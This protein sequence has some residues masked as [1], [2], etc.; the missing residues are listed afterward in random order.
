MDNLRRYFNDVGE[1]PLLSKEEEVSLSKKIKKGCKESFNTFIEHNLRLVYSIAVNYQGCGV[2]LMDLISEGNVGLH[3]AVEKFK[4]SKKTKFSTY[5]T[6]WIRQRILKYINNC[7]KTI[8]I[9]VYLYSDLK[10]VR[11]AKE[12]FKEEH[13][14]E[15]TLSQ[16][17]KI[18]GV[19]GEKIK[20][21]LP[22]VNGPISIDAKIREGDSFT[23]G[24][25]IASIK[26]TALE[27][28]LSKE[29]SS[30]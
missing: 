7:G 28:L 8:R 9:P 21:L 25:S 14:M 23:I 1:K 6:Y 22:H 5:A 3:T 10:K 16:L 4:P 29:N 20:Q 15:A 13:S 2:D 11:I 17:V 27:S 30:V 24:D 18:S 12:N 19:S 26:N